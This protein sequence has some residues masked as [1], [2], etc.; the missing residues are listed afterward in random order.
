MEELR[1]EIRCGKCLLNQFMTVSRNCRKCGAAL[2]PPEKIELEPIVSDS[3]TFRP[4]G[5]TM[6]FQISQRVSDLRKLRGLTQNEL[7]QKL[8]CQRTYISK[9]E[10]GRSLPFLDQINRFAAAFG[11]TAYE[12]ILS[13]EEIRRQNFL[14]DPFI[15]E[16]AADLPK[17]NTEQRKQV[18]RFAG[19]LER[20]SAVRA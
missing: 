16:L 12:F 9:I 8:G 19:L 4:F 11:I 15:A 13:P 14:A 1:E 18:L 7:A 3:D 5:D 17:L 10:N 6:Q 2:D 20:Q